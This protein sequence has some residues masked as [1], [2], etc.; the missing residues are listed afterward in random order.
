MCDRRWM[1]LQKHWSISGIQSWKYMVSR[2]LVGRECWRR[3]Q[4]LGWARIRQSTMSLGEWCSPEKNIYAKSFQCS[5]YNILSDGVW[6]LSSWWPL[7]SVPSWKLWVKIEKYFP[8]STISLADYDTIE[9]VTCR[10]FYIYDQVR[11]LR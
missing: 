4:V 11:I 8:A 1:S 2:R 3:C 7:L 10:S 9:T 6:W 5:C